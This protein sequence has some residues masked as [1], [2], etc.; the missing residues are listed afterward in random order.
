MIADRGGLAGGVGRDRVQSSWPPTVPFSDGR[1]NMARARG[2]LLLPALALALAGCGDLTVSAA[3]VET[4]A[5]EQ[6]SQQFPVDSVDCP[7]GLSAEVGETTR[8]VLVSEGQAFEMTATVTS[9][10]GSD[11]Q[12]DLE[13]TDEL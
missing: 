10:E 12:F 11:V 4:Q 9:V 1:S 2:F 6:F 7:E 3:D 13:L 5:Q 8:C